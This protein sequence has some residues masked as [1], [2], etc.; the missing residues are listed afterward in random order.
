[1][2]LLAFLVS[3]A[4]A[5]TEVRYV[6]NYDGDTVKFNVGKVRI[7]GVDA[8][9]MSTKNPCERALA[10]RAREFVRRELEKATK[11][12]LT[13]NKKRDIYGRTLAEVTYDGKDLREELLDRNLAVPYVPKKRQ[14][15]NWCHV[16]EKVK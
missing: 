12:T 4:L 14:R 8:A 7:L 10:L 2:F 3:A 6:K 15:V 1:M 11:I 13:N 5:Q 16:Q 9:E